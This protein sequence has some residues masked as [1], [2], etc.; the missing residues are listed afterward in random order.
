VVKK[1]HRANRKLTQTLGRDP[2][3]SELAAELEIPVERVV[4]LQ[5]MI[6]DPVS[7]EAPVGDGESL[8]ADMVEDMNVQRPDDQVAGTERHAQLREALESLNERTRRVLE[9]RFGLGDREPATL[10]QVGTEIG[11]TRERVR[12]IETRALRELETKNPALKDF[13]PGAD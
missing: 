3:P 8:F 7:L 5:R 1:L 10:E 12:Q 9:A 13:L 6:E 4:E 2:L 11:V